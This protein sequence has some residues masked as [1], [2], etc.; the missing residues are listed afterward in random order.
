MKKT[1][2]IVA[3]I[4][5][6]FALFFAYTNSGLV[7]AENQTSASTTAKNNTSSQNQTQSASTQPGSIGQTGQSQ[8]HS[9][10]SQS[11]S[12]PVGTTGQSQYAQR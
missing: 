9:G 1:I 11:Q 7:F 10:Q 5:L 3:S 6:S 2:S 12:G 4:A 8:S